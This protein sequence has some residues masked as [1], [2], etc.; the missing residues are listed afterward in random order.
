MEEGSNKNI[1]KAIKVLTVRREAPKHTIIVF[2]ILYILLSLCTALVS[3]SKSIIT[4]NGNVLPVSSFTGV[5]S[6]VGNLCTV[7]M[8]LYYKKLGFVVSLVLITVQL[9]ILLSN[10][11]VL[12]N[13]ASLPGIFTMVFTVSMMVIIYVNHKRLERGQQ[14][15]QN[16][17]KQ[18]ATA[19]INAIDAKDVY[20]HGHS[21]RVAD[22]SRRL[23]ELAN[24]S[25]EECEEIYYAALLHDVG[26]IGVPNSIINK[27]GKLTDNEYDTIKQ[28]PELGA[29]ILDKISE[30]PYLSIG[31]HYHHERYDGN[32]YPEG[33]KGEEIPEIARIIAVADAY[34][35]MTSTRSYR[36]TIPQDKVREEILKCSGSQFDPEYARLMLHLIDID[37]EFQ[38]RERSKHSEYNAKN[39]LVIGDY[40]SAVS[41]GILI[42]GFKT[43]VS[44]SVYSDDEAEGVEPTPLIVVFDALDGLVHSDEKSIND[45]LYFEY[46]EIGFG[47]R[48][49]T[50][51]ARKIQS[52]VIDK[53]SPDIKSDRDYKIEAVRI[54]DHAMIRIIGMEQTTEVTIALPD[55]TRYMYIGLTG[56]HCRISGL[57]TSKDITECPS[58]YISRIAE[59][60]SY[61]AD[62]PEGDVPNVQID[63]FRSAHSKGTPIKDGLKISFHA[64]SL[65]TARLVWHCPFIDV[66]CSDDGEV[67]GKN[68]RDLAFIRFDGECW[69][70]DPSS[71]TEP[72]VKQTELFDGWNMW[73]DYNHKGYDATVSFKVK[74]NTITIITDNAGISI[75]HKVILSG[76]DKTVFASVTGDQVAISDIKYA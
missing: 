69:E 20:T 60:I 15:M 38:M 3:R 6:S 45:M 55:S 28:H 37:G 57:D 67:G 59:E 61:V 13:L 10:I 22:Y 12:H 23:A 52:K 29:H 26:K 75:A 16:L 74:G 63:G 39:D 24:K 18:T 34:D 48:T 5:V 50:G 7:L 1:E 71:K 4:I 21:S 44:L 64:K 47:G 9:P 27:K 70:C 31:A 17:F 33:L 8:V 58:D 43:T 35:A 51:G 54:K 53:G 49:T 11:F 76:I 32:G 62:C 42:T 56:E 36:S 66:F 41:N 46:G 65:P 25:P 19:L 40:R 30:Y 2:V 73:N 68:Y 14:R 72:Y